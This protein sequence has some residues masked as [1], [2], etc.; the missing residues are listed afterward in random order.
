MRASH[1]GSDTAGS[2]ATTML[3]GSAATVDAVTAAAGYRYVYDGE[4]DQFANPAAVYVITPERRIA[5]VLSGLGLDANDLRLA[6]VDA[7]RGQI[8]TFV[9]HLRLFCYGFDPA[10]GI[11][12]MSIERALRVMALATG[13]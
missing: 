10:Q 13:S 3:I 2:T 1:L 6:L 8:G 7:G 4:H 11:Y 5:R 12:T 9:D